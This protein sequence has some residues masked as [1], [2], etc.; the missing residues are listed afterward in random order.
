MRVDTCFQVSISDLD[1]SE[2]KI[3]QFLTIYFCL[4]MPVV[5]VHSLHLALQIAL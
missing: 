1:P 3:Y 4:D 2:G 5:K